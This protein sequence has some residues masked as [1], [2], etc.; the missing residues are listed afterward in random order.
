M[1]KYIIKNRITGEI[2]KKHNKYP[3]KIEGSKLVDF[4]YDQYNIFIIV[5]GNVPKCDPDKEF[6]KEELIYVDDY[7]KTNE[8][9]KVKICQKSWNKF[10]YSKPVIIDKL[11]ESLG[12][13]LDREYPIWERTK[14]AGEGSY[15]LNLMITG[16]LTEEEIKRKEYIDST[17]NWITNCRLER[18]RRELEYLTNNI[19][20]SFEWE[21]RPK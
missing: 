14:H 2:I 18:D 20:P 10:L 15:I 12:N 8:Y 5:E 21:A 6:L 13:F 17:Y 11:N 16:N 1:F 19:F 9:Y 7:Y 4:D 3:N